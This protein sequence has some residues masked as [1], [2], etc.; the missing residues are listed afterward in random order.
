MPSSHDGPV[1]G[2]LPPVVAVGLAAADG[3]SVGVGVEGLVDGVADWVGVGVTE[4]LGLAVVDSEGLGVAEQI[5][6]GP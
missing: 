3:L 1:I 5:A 4:A 2:R 6:Q